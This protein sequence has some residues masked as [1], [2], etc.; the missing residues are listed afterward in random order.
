MILFQP[1]NKTI[2]CLK[3]QE[4]PDKMNVK[5]KLESIYTCPPLYSF[6][7]PSIKNRNAGTPRIPNRCLIS[8]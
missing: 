4:D 2:S 3:I 5:N 8:L 6:S 1:S 7:L